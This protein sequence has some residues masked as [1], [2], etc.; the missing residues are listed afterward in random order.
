M[1]GRPT[2][3]ARELGEMESLRFSRLDG[4][5]R[6][7]MEQERNAKQCDDGEPGTERNREQREAFKDKEVF[8]LR[9]RNV[10]K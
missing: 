9:I 1:S 3:K 7:L 6:L 5:E 10:C 4:E 2:R 8:D